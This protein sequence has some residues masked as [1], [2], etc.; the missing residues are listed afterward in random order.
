MCGICAAV[1]LVMP[2]V[3]EEVL[4]PAS[5]RFAAAKSED[6]VSF[7]RHVMPLLGRLGCNGRACHGSFQGRG[8]FRLSLFGYDFQ[9]DHEALTKG[10]LPRVDLKAPTESLILE[11]PT[12]VISHKGGK[13]IQ[14][15]SWQFH[16]IRRWIE[17]GAKNDAS[18]TVRLVQLSVSPDHHVFG[19]QGEK[20]QLQVIARWSDGTAEDVTDLTRF[21]SN[22]DAVAAIDDSGLVTAAGKGDTHVVA[23][24]DNGVTPIPVM[25]PV[26]DQIGSRYPEVPAPTKI[27]QL[28]M[29]KL[30]QCGIVPS[31]VCTDAEFLRRIGI[32][33]IGTLPTSA[34]IDRFLSDSSPDKRAKKIDELLSRPEYAIWWATR[35]CDYTGN[36]GV[37]RDVVFA[38][39]YARQWYG[40]VHRR[41]QENVSYDRIVAGMVL[42]TS[43]KPGQSLEEYSKEMSSYYRKD[44]PADFSLRETMPHYWARTSFEDPK[45][46]A[47]GFSYAF[48]GVHLQCA[49][50]HKHPF[51]QWTK[52]DFQQFTAFF[53]RIVYGTPPE[54]REQFV[55]MVDASV[56]AGTEKGKR[57]E[58]MLA[59]LAREGKTVPFH[60]VYIGQP[61]DNG[62]IKGPVKPV[63]KK[64]VPAGRNINPKLL[65][66]PE[67]P[68][69][70]ADDL[71]QVLLDWLRRP[72]N[73]YFARAF[74]NRVWASY[75]NVGIIEPPDDLSL[76]NPPSNKPLLDYLTRGF[77]EH[78][79]DMKWLHREIVSSRT[80]QLSWKP[81]ET[82]RL[83]T[84]NFSHAIPRRMPAEAAYDAIYQATAALADIPT[85]QREATQRATGIGSASNPKV[86]GKFG[87]ILTVFGKP[88]RRE[89]C[90]CE[91]SNDPSLLQTLF[92]LND[93]QIQSML[94]RPG[95]WVAQ[96]NQDFSPSKPGKGDPPPVKGKKEPA[97][98]DD[99]AT[100]AKMIAKLEARLKELEKDG[101]EAGI[102]KVKRALADLKRPAPPQ[103]KAIKPEEEGKA[104]RE[105]FLRTVCRAPT[106]K[107]MSVAREY[108]KESASFGDGVRDLLWAL[109]NT[110]E[111]LVNH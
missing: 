61:G 78:G 110:N 40:W 16:T 15:D 43:R 100:R 67:L 24:Y 33:L 53:D 2:A 29:A 34:E 108:F 94:T 5:K 81:N 86:R 46:R 11:K 13:R 47:L 73:P 98:P 55:K 102:A 38:Q 72:D 19:K 37:Y 80:Y 92:L 9:A 21:R 91:R 6:P 65:G 18:A 23:F 104:I 27:D 45:E 51:D 77:I 26:S 95:G 39:D 66:E 75:F 59:N 28:V 57:A 107:E 97:Q 10:K 17:D 62:K 56:P 52:T 1:Y 111:F 74:V 70:A 84:H 90:D 71:R 4:A 63:V 50:C 99:A 12:L 106:E 87:N 7:R 14:P 96:L 76:A 105:V 41:V 44:S 83:D 69:D 32:D 25:L 82:N 49:Q 88:D 31:E 93:A 64:K 58:G 54:D 68:R 89:N 79:Y 30:R 48:L 36:S 60:E 8:G 22:D 35:I 101:N 109:I 20:V 42:G 3:A 103:P 85:W